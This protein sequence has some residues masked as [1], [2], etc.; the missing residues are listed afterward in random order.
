MKA[1]ILLLT[2]GYNDSDANSICARNVAEELYS[3]GNVVDMCCIKKSISNVD[4]QTSFGKLFYVLNEY[5]KILCKLEQKGISFLQLPKLIRYAIKMKQRIKSIGYTRTGNQYGDTIIRKDF[6]AAVQRNQMSGNYDV[7]VAIAQ[8]FGWA[9]LANELKER[10]PGTK[11]YLYM[12]DPYIYN[13][14]LSRNKIEYRKRQFERFTN[15]LDGIIFTRGIKEEAEKNGLDIP[16]KSIVVDLPNMQ[17]SVYVRQN[18][19]YKDKTELMFAGRFYPDIRNPQKMFDVMEQVL[20]SSMIFSLFSQGCD[21]LVEN[22]VKKCST[23]QR[24]RLL[25]HSQYCKYFEGVDILVNIENSISNQLPSKVFEYIASGK[26]IINFYEYETGMGL[27]YFRRYP[28]AI[29]FN[30]N[31]YDEDD[32]MRLRT[33]I[34]ENKDKR[35][36]YEEATNLMKEARSENVLSDIADFVLSGLE[37]ED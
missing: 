20:D 6:Y 15:N 5:T 11:I 21:K 30:L 35:L 13:Y 18:K 19:N 7:I 2:V 3:R 33:F 28:L 23:A 8:P 25:P 24:H 29:N 37:D 31:S 36:S 12:L 14:T 4:G 22:F 16:K 32:I 10:Y 26:P 9:V 27:H 1:K 17:P 34:K